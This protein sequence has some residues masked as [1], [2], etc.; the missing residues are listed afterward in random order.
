VTDEPKAQF[1]DSGASGFLT[2]ML[3]THGDTDNRPER[4]IIDLEYYRSEGRRDVY[5]A[6]VDAG[7]PVEHCEDE[8]NRC[9][10]CDAEAPH[11]GVPAHTAECLWTVANER[12]KT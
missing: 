7:E 12:I 1:T 6:I 8:T 5:H 3:L 10:W 2:P 9:L 4:V 11:C